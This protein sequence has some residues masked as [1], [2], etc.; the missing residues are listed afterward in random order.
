MAQSWGWGPPAARTCALLA[1]EAVRLLRAA[2]VVPAAREEGGGAVQHH[3]TA[4]L[5]GRSCSEEPPQRPPPCATAPKRHSQQRAGRG[6]TRGVK[7][8]EGGGAGVG[9][10]G[11]WGGLPHR[12][13]ATGSGVGAGGLP[14]CPV[15]IQER[16]L[17]HPL[18]VLLRGMEADPKVKSHVEQAG[19]DEGYG[20]PRRESHERP[21]GPPALALH[22]AISGDG[23][24]G[25]GGSPGAG[26]TLLQG[27]CDGEQLG[28]LLFAG[29]LR[30]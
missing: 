24:R 25:H 7:A 6:G 11:A 15:G 20:P 14:R 16:L 3:R 13:V 23:A 5:G 28:L 29:E 17:L 27:V 9:G 19:C 1:E 22:L 8:S 30:L 26:P 12:Y 18:E 2:P 4:G 21:G 10:R